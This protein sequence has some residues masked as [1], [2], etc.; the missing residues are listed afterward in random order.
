MKRQ[1]EET[2]LCCQIKA[3]NTT[4]VPRYAF[5]KAVHPIFGLY[6]SP[7]EHTYDGTSGFGKHKDSDLVFGISKLNGKPNHPARQTL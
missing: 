1:N 5:F 3:V 4:S 7:A 2:L 6:G